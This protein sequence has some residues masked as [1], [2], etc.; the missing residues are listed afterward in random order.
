MKKI[1]SHYMWN[2]LNLFCVGYKN[3]HSNGISSFKK[4]AGFQAGIYC[5]WDLKLNTMFFYI[6]ICS[7][8]LRSFFGIIP[9]GDSS[10]VTTYTWC[11]WHFC[12]ICS[13]FVTFSTHVVIC[14][15]PLQ[16]LL[17]KRWRSVLSYH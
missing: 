10:I 4:I 17:S 12:F 7:K 15:S 16:K 14:W 6:S 8:V 13:Y 11:W 1:Y 9:V 3:H 2:V 5:Q